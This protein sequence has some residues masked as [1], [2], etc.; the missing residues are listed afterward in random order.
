MVAN[1]ICQQPRLH[2]RASHVHDVDGF[3]AGKDQAVHLFKKGREGTV[4][5]RKKQ[6]I[7]PRGNGCGVGQGI[8]RGRLG[9]QQATAGR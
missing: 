7:V 2:V 5:R 8:H 6:G 1:G 9:L 3:F 4:A